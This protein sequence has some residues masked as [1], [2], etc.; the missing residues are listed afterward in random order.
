MEKRNTDGSRRKRNIDGKGI[1]KKRA[2]LVSKSH[3]SGWEFPLISYVWLTF[4]Q[5]TAEIKHVSPSLMF[6]YNVP[7]HM[8]SDF[9]YDSN[10]A[11]RGPFVLPDCFLKVKMCLNMPLQGKCMSHRRCK[12]KKVPRN[13]HFLII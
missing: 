1:D 12:N 8:C 10:S 6:C 11:S 9:S 13:S 3:I 7:P 4:Y 2:L 5:A